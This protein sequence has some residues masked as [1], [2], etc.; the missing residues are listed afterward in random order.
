MKTYDDKLKENNSFSQK[1]FEYSKDEIINNI[2]KNDLDI[3]ND[4]LHKNN[5]NL[6][7]TSQNSDN[8]NDNES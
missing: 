2:S 1:S 7:N 6:S 4:Y 5:I 8:E 3:F